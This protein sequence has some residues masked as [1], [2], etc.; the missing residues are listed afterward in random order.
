MVEAILQVIREIPGSRVL[1]CAPSNAASDLLAV[2][3]V[4]AKLMAESEILRLIS[5]SQ[6]D[7]NDELDPAL[8]NIVHYGKM[9]AKRL[10]KYRL[11]VVTLGSAVRLFTSGVPQGHFTHLF[12]DEA[13]QATEP[14][15]L[16]PISL[17]MVLANKWGHV[18]LAGDPMQ[19]GPVILS[20]LAGKFGMNRSL[21]QRLMEDYEIYQKDPVTGARNSGYTTKLV[22]NFRSH[23]KLLLL[24]SKLFY[25]NELVACADQ[26]S[27]GQLC[28]F[29]WLPKPG[30]PLVFH[31]VKGHHEKGEHTPSLLN[32]TEVLLT[33]DYVQKLIKS[34]PQDRIG[35]VSPY[36]R[37]VRMIKELLS[38]RFNI[39]DI[40]VGSVEEFQGGEKE[41]MIFST[42]RS[43]V[44]L[45]HNNNNN[46]KK[47]R[48]GL[49]FLVNQRRFNVGISRAKSLMI[50]IGD[51][52]LLSRDQHWGELIDF[53]VRNGAYTG[54]SVPNVP[55]KKA[56]KNK[57]TMVKC[58]N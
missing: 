5:P 50:V 46:N 44:V 9:Q 48:P 4:Q 29:S 39:S 10:M 16:I 58:V 36:R 25:D 20:T 3:L 54:V 42:V 28:N 1:V 21:M 14:E 2:R 24:P 6:Q 12:I 40:Q 45:V 22:K 23:E 49:G 43:S 41:V 57:K 18:I 38:S 15:C 32:E 30:F 8:D 11:I 26:K 51:P 53:A 35:I 52:R 13:G 34:V 7:K 37:Q 17:S 27:L 33:L 55:S 47:T 56:K 19:L 31:G